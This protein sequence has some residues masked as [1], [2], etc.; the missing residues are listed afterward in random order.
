MKLW[1]EIS[2]SVKVQNYIVYDSRLVQIV[3][4][5]CNGLEI[6]DVREPDVKNWLIRKDPNAGKD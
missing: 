5:F 6:W 1:E 2:F 4:L 3:D